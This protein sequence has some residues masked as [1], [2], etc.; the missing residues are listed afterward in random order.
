MGA[1]KIQRIRFKKRVTRYALLMLAPSVLVMILLL[2]NGNFSLKV[3]VTALAF[4]GIT[5]LIYYR[6]L[7]S[8]IY[9]PIQSASNLVSAIREGDYSMQS[10][11]SSTQDA[12]G[13]LY[14]EINLLIEDLKNQHQRAVESRILL[15]GIM[16]HTDVAIMAFDSHHRITLSN[17]AGCE[18]LDVTP[19]ACVGH[20][21][22]EF[23]VEEL[24][25]VEESKPFRHQFPGASGRWTVRRKEFREDGIPQ[26]LLLIQDLSKSLREEERTAWKRLIRVMGHELNNSLAPIKSIS[27]TL[28]TLVQRENLDEE[29]KEDLEDGLHVIQKRADALSRFVGD[30]SKIA[31][32]PQPDRSHFSLNALIDRIVNLHDFKGSSI[33]SENCCQ[34]EL[35]ADEAQIEQLL[36]N[37]TKNAIEANGATGGVT[38]IRCKRELRWILIEVYDEGL[39]LASSD[40]LFIPFYST[41]PGGSGI[42]LTL[43]QQIAENHEGSLELVNRDDRQGCVARVTIPLDFETDAAEDANAV[44]DVEVSS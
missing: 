39:G 20:T 31:K 30:Y 27:G 13:E 16:D 41:K 26:S 21:A 33:S 3:W 9:R 22:E 32:L 15:N 6:W 34:V 10:R 38:T 8:S 2:V 24:L 42:G 12:L 5:T 18:L 37:L 19:G 35:F 28:N 14:H 25:S 7:M 36:I 4:V 43:S 17:R 11:P 1:A 44:T 40:N 23:G 29:L